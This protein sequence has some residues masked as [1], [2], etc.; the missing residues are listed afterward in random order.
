[1]LI[2]VIMPV[3]NAERYLNAAINSILTQTFKNF[4]FLIINDGSNDRSEEIIKSYPDSRIDYIKNEQNRGIVETLNIGLQRSKGK[5][6]VRMDADD[7]SF[8]DRLKT[9]LDFMQ[10]HPQC[11][12]CG[13]RAIAINEKGDTLYKIRRPT[14]DNEVKVQHLFRNSFIHPSVIIDAEIAK[15]L[16]YSPNYEHAE[17]YYLFSQIA[18]DHQVAN[19][20]NN[21]I[22]YRVHP[23]NITSKKQHEMNKSEMKTISFLLSSL[24]EEKV[25]D[26]VVSLHHSFLTRNFENIDTA[27]IEAHLLKI[28]DINKIKHT[29]NN[30][31]L[32]I[33]LQNDV[34][35]FCSSE[36]KKMLYVLL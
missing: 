28:K 35:T 22:Y 17:D 27:K 9:Q 2:T 31:A 5:Y 19:L 32:A 6:I 33:E 3:Y 10:S 1:M 24:F 11:R 29:Y 18:K 36:K 23:E 16:K 7:I 34:L 14:L 26:E 20:E 12:L 15:R 30:N 13:T 21:L 8:P 4:E 25:S